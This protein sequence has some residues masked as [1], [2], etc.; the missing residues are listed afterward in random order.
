MTS[1]SADLDERTK[2]TASLV[3]RCLHSVGQVNVA[4]A[5]DVSESW[6]SKWKT[7]ELDRTTRLLLLC[8]LKLVPVNVHCFHQKDVEMLMHGAQRWLGD[9]TSSE[10]LSWD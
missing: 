1:L 10:Q 5:L 4:K 2:K 8:G 9:L 7:D 3:L 6:L